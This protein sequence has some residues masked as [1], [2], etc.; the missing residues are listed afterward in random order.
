MDISPV[1]VYGQQQAATAGEFATRVLK[2]GLDISQQQAADL[3]S[4]IDGQRGVG[5]NL[6]VSA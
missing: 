6:N 2:R 5:Q 4:L 3:I 1:A